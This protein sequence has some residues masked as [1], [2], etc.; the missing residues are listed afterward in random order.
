MALTF[1]FS[2]SPLVFWKRLNFEYLKYLP[3]WITDSFYSKSKEF[4]GVEGTEA[5]KDWLLNFLCL[6]LSVCSTA[7][8]S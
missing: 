4:R 8:S 7:I 6:S 1:L 3:S 2:T 5:W